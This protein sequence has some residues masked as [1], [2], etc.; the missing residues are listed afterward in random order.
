MEHFLGCLVQSKAGHDRGEIY[1]VIREEKDRAEL[2]NGRGRTG[3]RPKIKN[4]KHLTILRK[5]YPAELTE[6]IRKGGIP[7]DEEIRRIIRNVKK[8]IF[9]V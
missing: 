4:V 8:E 5:G 9:N 3:A 1:L 7:A 6:Q 2:V